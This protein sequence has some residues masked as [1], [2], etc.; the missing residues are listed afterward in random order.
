MATRYDKLPER[1]AAFVA[2][3]AAFIWLC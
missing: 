3:T 2:L 1:F